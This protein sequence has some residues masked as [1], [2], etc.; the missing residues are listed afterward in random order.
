MRREEPSD[1]PVAMESV[2][3]DVARVK[4]RAGR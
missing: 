2:Q 3:R 4:E 1:M